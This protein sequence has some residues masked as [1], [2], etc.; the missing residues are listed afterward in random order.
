MAKPVTHSQLKMALEPLATQ[1][2]VKKTVDDSI[3]KAIAPLA[4]KEALEMHI[5]ALWS[6]MNRRFAEQEVNQARHAGA[7]LE[8]VHTMFKAFEEKYADLPR[9]VARLEAERGTP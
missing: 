2:F 6:E 1:E 3:A 9:R 5:G 7:I 4:T 8:A